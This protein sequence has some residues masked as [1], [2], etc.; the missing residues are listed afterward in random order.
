MQELVL[1]LKLNPLMQSEQTLLEEQAEQL[2]LLQLTQDPLVAE[3]PSMQKAQKL[4]SLQERQLD[5]LQKTQA[6]LKT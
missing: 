2:E 3:N 6:P 5:V 1:W 4:V